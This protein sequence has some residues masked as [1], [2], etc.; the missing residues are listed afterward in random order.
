MQERNLIKVKEDRLSLITLISKEK[1][2]ISKKTQEEQKKL[3]SQ[4]TIQA[5]Q[6]RGKSI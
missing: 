1:I 2:L 4:R 3:K 5:S 6:N